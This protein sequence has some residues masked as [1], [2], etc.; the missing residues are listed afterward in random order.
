MVTAAI[1]W[2]KAVNAVS[3]STRRRVSPYSV[4]FSIAPAT[5]EAV[6]MMKLRTSSS[7]SRGAAVCSSMTPSTRPERS[8][9]GT[10]TID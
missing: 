10:A 3:A 4:A 6:C 5:S 8:G 1:R 9:S 7:N 2:L